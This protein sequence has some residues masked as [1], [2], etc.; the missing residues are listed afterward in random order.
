M[1]PK[2]LSREEIDIIKNATNVSKGIEEVVR[3]REN[4]S[5]NSRM[6]SIIEELRLAKLGKN[7]DPQNQVNPP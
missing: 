6:K 1:S 5:I 2:P 7:Q 3:I 4:K